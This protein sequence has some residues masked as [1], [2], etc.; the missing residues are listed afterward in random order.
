MCHI[1]ERHGDHV[2]LLYDIPDSTSLTQKTVASSVLPITEILAIEDHKFYGTFLHVAFESQSLL[3][4]TSDQTKI[5][6]RT[7][8]GD[9]RGWMG[10]N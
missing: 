4:P 2:H 9:Q 1:V 6:W 10:A 8:E 7:G 5:H 3:E